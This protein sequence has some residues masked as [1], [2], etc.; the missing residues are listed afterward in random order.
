MKIVYF[1]QYFTTP[2]GSYGTRVYEFTREWVKL[3]HEVTVVSSVYYKSDLRATK[4]VD[5]LVFDGV[6]VILLNIYIDNKQSILKRI[7]GFIAYSV[8]SSYY[9]L[10]LPADVVISSSGPLTVGLPGLI[11][12]YI[13]RKRLV[14]EVRDLWPQGAI[15][16]G[17]IKNRLLKSLAYWLEKRCYLASS[18]IIALSPGMKQNIVER[19]KLNNVVSVTNSANIELFC[20]GFS[21]SISSQYGC[22]AIYTGNIG[23]VN[24][25]YWLVNAARILKKMNSEVKIIMVGDGQQREQIE[26][27]KVEED[28]KNLI[29]LQLMPKEELV[30]FIQN[31]MVSLVPLKGQPILDTSSPNKF[32]ESLSAGVPVIQNTKGWMK[33]FLDSHAVGFTLDPDDATALAEKLIYLSRQTD[34]LKEMGNRARKIAELNFDKVILAKKMLNSFVDELA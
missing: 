13:R 20:P 17:L 23:D 4:N 2:K 3:G 31:A 12:R 16:L 26:K 11:A 25:S 21:E 14:F 6:K 28:L 5:Y 19:F 27:I 15:E 9:A 32:F 29:I 10:T 30:K 24:N 33:D 22:Y 7:W 34:Q 18:K 1:Y 8:A